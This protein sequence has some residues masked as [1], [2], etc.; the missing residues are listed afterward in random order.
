MPGWRVKLIRLVDK[1]KPERLHQA[2]LIRARQLQRQFLNAHGIRL[3][4]ESQDFN[5][6]VV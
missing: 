5:L 6:E 4:R 1:I 3:A 2:H